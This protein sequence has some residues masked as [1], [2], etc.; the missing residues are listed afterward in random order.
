[1]RF[2]WLT[3]QVVCGR[4]RARQL[5]VR[6]QQT[7]R[8]RYSSYGVRVCVNVCPFF[9]STH[10]TIL[11]S[12]YHTHIEIQFNRAFNQI[13]IDELLICK[14]FQFAGLCKSRVYYNFIIYFWGAT[15]MME[16]ATSARK[17]W[18][19]QKHTCI[20]TKHMKHLFTS[21][22]IHAASRME[23]ARTI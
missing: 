1:M 23:R 17:R 3:K 4:A 7:K 8:A 21:S 9:T 5:V 20:L 14:W 10:R 2:T 11:A 13:C 12:L 15:T 18:R 6:W 16:W 22:L 19:M